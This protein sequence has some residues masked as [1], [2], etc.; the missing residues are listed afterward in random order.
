MKNELTL[1]CFRIDLYMCH[2]TTILKV[3]SASKVD[4]CHHKVLHDKSDIAQFS[5][6]EGYRGHCEMRITLLASQ[7]PK[8]SK[9]KP[10]TSLQSCYINR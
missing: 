4:R 9:E 1:P 6:P 2:T 7:F 5:Q 8:R 10:Q 3:E